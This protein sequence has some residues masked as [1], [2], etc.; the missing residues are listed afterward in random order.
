M[1]ELSSNICILEGS[2]GP[3]PW[4]RPLPKLDQNQLKIGPPKKQ[5]FSLKM[6]P[7]GLQKHILPIKSDP[8][9]QSTSQQ[10][11][12]AK[13]AGGRGEALKQIKNKNKLDT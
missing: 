13:G 9:Q 2:E 10:F 5:R 12:S 4:R 3:N 11:P 8:V 1:I 6:E 7:Q